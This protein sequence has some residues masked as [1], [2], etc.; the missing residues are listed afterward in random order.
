MVAVAIIVLV[1]LEAHL[2][3]PVI[4]SRSVEVHPLAIALSVLTGTLLAGIVGALLAVPFVAFLNATIHA[5]RSPPDPGP[6]PSAGDAAHGGERDGGERDGGE[7]DGDA[8]YDAG[9]PDPARSGTDAGPPA[10]PGGV[11]QRTCSSTNGG[12]TTR[13]AEVRPR[14]SSSTRSPS[15][16]PAAGRRAAPARCPCAR[17]ARRCRW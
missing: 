4:M 2:L 15:P 10:D 9:E 1:Q 13:T 12:R 16:T 17:S 8:A 7:R 6:D 14:T 3:Q 11:V 5:L